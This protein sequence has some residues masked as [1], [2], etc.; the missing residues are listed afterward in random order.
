MRRADRRDL[1]HLRDPAAAAVD[2]EAG[3]AARRRRDQRDGR[4]PLRGRRRLDRRPGHLQRP[5]GDDRAHRAA[6]EGDDQRSAPRPD[7]QTAGRRPE[8]DLS[9]HPGHPERSEVVDRAGQ[10]AAGRRNPRRTGV[11]PDRGPGGAEP[12]GARHL[13]GGADAR[14]GHE[15]RRHGGGSA[16]RLP[17]RPG[18]QGRHPGH[19]RRSSHSARRCARRPGRRDRSVEDR[20]AHF[21]GRLRGLLWSGRADRRGPARLEKGVEAGRRGSGRGR[22]GVNPSTQGAA[23]RDDRRPRPTATRRLAAHNP[24]A[25]VDDRRLHRHALARP[26][27]RGVAQRLAPDRPQPRPPRPAGDRAH[28]GGRPRGG[29]ARRPEVALHA[30]PRRARGVRRGRRAQRGPQC[31]RPRSNAGARPFGQEADPAARLPVVLRG[32]RERRPAGRGT[33]LPQ[34]HARARGDLRDRA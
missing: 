9:D 13:R 8:P 16:Q 21:C 31:R 17:P 22:G 30:D 19:G 18:P 1:E 2:P 28:L 27:Q 11:V 5:R 29:R 33:S 12:A 24:A 34:V 14:R 26:V 23:T 15:P 7:R 20:R 25:A 3:S 10:R 32:R 4:L 6:G